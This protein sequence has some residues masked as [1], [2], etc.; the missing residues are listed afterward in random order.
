M[1]KLPVVSVI[2]VRLALG[3]IALVPLSVLAG[4]QAEQRLCTLAG[5]TVNS[6]T[7]QDV[8]GAKVTLRPEG[9]TTT[10]TKPQTSVS[11]L[12]GRFYFEN[13]PPGRFGL[14]AEKAGFEYYAWGAPSVLSLRRPIV[15]SAACEVPNLELRLVPLGAI[16]GRVLDTDGEPVEG[17]SLILTALGSYDDIRWTSAGTNVTDDRG[18]FRLPNLEHGAYCLMV[19]PPY[20]PPRPVPASAAGRERVPLPTYFP[21]GSD[22]ASAAKLLLAPGQNLSGITIILRSGPVYR[23]RGKVAGVS[24]EQPVTGLQLLL[25]PPEGAKW[26]TPEAL[27]ALAQRAGGLRTLRADGSFDLSNVEPGLY[28]VVLVR[29]GAIS[30]SLGRVEVAVTDKDAE[31]VVLP[32]SGLVQLQGTVRVESEQK[33]SLQAGIM[34]YPLDGGFVEPGEAV[35]PDGAFKV[36]GIPAGRY[37]VYVHFLPGRPGSPNGMEGLYVKSIQLIGSAT[38][39]DISDSGLD[40][41]SNATISIMV[42]GGTAN[43]TGVVKRGDKPA[44][45]RDLTLVPDRPLPGR[46][47]YYKLGQSDESGRFTITGVAPGDYFLYAWD[48]DL[49]RQIYLDPAFLKPFEGQGAR[50]SVRGTVIVE[51][52]PQVVPPL[53]R[54]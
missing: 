42:G 24:S 37:A 46:F 33:V 5:R 11:D 3:V 22:F 45:Y 44:A 19:V 4:A 47:L 21:S 18:Q 9:P 48:D 53:G 39:M 10:P 2:G 34:L 35:G 1:K 32:L 6:M 13:I 26:L 16:E 15:V 43:V 27:T 8:A 52:E 17:A 51:A 29:A 49:I 25:L 41:S 38:G 31:D 40:L 23:I 54:Q 20:R 14:T 7:G 50:V 12:Q 28:S 36:D 30:R